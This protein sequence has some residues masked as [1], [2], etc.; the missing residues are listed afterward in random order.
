MRLMRIQLEQCGSFM[1]DIVL[2]TVMTPPD[3]YAVFDAT[4]SYPS[5]HLSA[6]D[7][8]SLMR[9]WLFLP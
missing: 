2:I 7:V 3:F 1:I 4:T 6:K 9:V 8:I 5:G